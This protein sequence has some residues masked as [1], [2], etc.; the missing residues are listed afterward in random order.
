MLTKLQKRNN[1]RSLIRQNTNQERLDYRIKILTELSLNY[2]ILILL[3][4]IQNYAEGYCYNHPRFSNGSRIRTSLISYTKNLG[5]SEDDKIKYGWI[6]VTKNTYWKC[7]YL[8]KKWDSIGAGN[9]L[10]RLKYKLFPKLIF[11][12]IFNKIKYNPGNS[13]YLICLNRFNQMKIFSN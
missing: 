2:P 1:R 6:I 7:F 10:N 4:Y 13:G 8:S 3:Y 12:S 9:P 11:L 5:F